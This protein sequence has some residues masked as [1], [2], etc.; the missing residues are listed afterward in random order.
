MAQ[1]IEFHKTKVEFTN[2]TLCQNPCPHSHCKCPQ[3]GN[4]LQRTYYSFP[5][6]QYRCTYCIAYN[7]IIKDRV[8]KKIK[9]VIKDNIRLNQKS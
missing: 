6:P 1:E 5:Y 3:C 8:D 4:K 2:C 9:E 7:E